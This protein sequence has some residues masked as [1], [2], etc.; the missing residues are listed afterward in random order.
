MCNVCPWA[1]T[2]QCM[3]SSGIGTRAGGAAQASPGIF[4]DRAIINAHLR[5]SLWSMELFFELLSL[6]M[7]LVL[8]G[9]DV[10]NGIIV[11]KPKTT[12]AICQSLIATSPFQC[13]QGRRRGGS[14]RALLLF[15]KLSRAPLFAKWTIEMGVAYGMNNEKWVWLLEKSPRPSWVYSG[16]ATAG[17]QCKVFQVYAEVGV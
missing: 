12:T 13:V 11:K 1:G 17:W 14:R 10:Q 7:L 8:V 5:L 2:L 15:Q 16:S 9:H 4:G 6:L 3:H